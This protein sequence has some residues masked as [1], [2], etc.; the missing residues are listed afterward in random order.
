M[1]EL[2]SAYDYFNKELFGGELPA[3]LI[4]LQRK[5][6]RVMGYF[7]P[8]RFG[9]NK[10]KKQTDEIAMNPQYFKGRDHTEILQTLVHEMCH[11]W[12]QHFGMPSR[13]SYHNKEWAAKMIEIGLMPSSTG[14]EGGKT[15][16]QHMG[17]Y[18]IGGGPFV[19][20][21]KA[22]FKSGFAITWYDRAGDIKKPPSLITAPEGQEE[23]GE[24]GEV[25]TP[26]GT[27]RK[28]TC[29]SCDAT[30]Y[31]KGSLKLI[32]GECMKPMG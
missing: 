22:L 32:C 24:G 18:P 26:S 2:Q 7:S 28:F 14:K 17:D 11:L 19:V 5:G 30:A 27:R 29:P 4:T 8:Q 23:A 10:S 31:G 16:G 3:C 25:K 21:T 9:S 12:Q 15:T 20:A 1:N 13:R 6:H